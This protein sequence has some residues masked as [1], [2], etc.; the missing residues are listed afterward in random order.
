MMPK[1][2]EPIITSVEQAGV[3]ENG[4]LDIEVMARRSV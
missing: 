4:G 3:V 2:N 1:L